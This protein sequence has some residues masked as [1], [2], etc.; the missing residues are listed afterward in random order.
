MNLV[1]TGYLVI[2]GAYI[3]YSMWGFIRLE[4]ILL[5]SQLRK[6]EHRFEDFVASLL[7]AQSLRLI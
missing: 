7:I 6:V 3:V 5:V 1:I 2:A 4:V